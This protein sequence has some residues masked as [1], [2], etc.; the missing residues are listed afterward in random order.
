M[1]TIH[2]S[3]NSGLGGPGMW[4]PMPL[5]PPARPAEEAPPPIWSQ[6]AAPTPA[7]TPK[8]GQGQ[9]QAQKGQESEA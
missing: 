4:D 6:P 1:A 8:K 2:E 9:T 5:T 7:A 3:T